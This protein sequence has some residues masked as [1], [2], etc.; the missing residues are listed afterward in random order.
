M[1]KKM[2]LIVT[3]FM[4][5]YMKTNRIN[6]KFCRTREILA[7]TFFLWENLTRNYYFKSVSI[8]LYDKSMWQSAVLISW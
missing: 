2:L 8:I 6:L 5:Q 7:L 4:T 3:I 1:N